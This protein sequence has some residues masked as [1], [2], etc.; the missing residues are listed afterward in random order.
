MK[1]F[2]CDKCESTFPQAIEEIALKDEH[3]EWHTFDF[4]APCKNSLQQEQEA[5]V[6]SFFKDKLKKK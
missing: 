3:G 4:C 1:T 2:T 5:P 6:K